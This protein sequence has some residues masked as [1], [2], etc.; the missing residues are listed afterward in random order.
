MSMGDDEY[1]VDERA[2]RRRRSVVTFLV[3]ALLLFFAVWYALSYL[4]ADDERRAS[5]RST[6]TPTTCP[7]QPQDVVIN[8][9]NGTT[10]DGLAA[11]VARDLRE[12]GFAV[13]RIE[14]YQR[15]SKVGGIG[16]IR[17]GERG[18]HKV[19]VIAR[20]TGEMKQVN[21]KRKKSVIDV[22]VGK[23]FTQLVPV[24]QARG[25]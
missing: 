6:T 22:V 8:V 24:S 1:E 15:S 5:G 23:D 14:N 11:N 2:S 13:R 10:R 20:H 3:V 18:A 9:Y 16:Q 25:C 17:Y 21:D 12:R 4:R 19:K 7:I